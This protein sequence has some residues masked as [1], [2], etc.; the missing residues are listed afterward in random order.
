MIPD[1]VAL[2]LHDQ[3]T[4]GNPLS[5]EEKNQLQEWYGRHDDEERASLA[6]AA[7]PDMA[8]VRGSLT[9]PWSNSG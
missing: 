5:P 1:S 9:L 7:A 2:G 3:V 4:R 8:Q 6:Q